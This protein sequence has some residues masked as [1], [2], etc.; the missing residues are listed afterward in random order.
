MTSDRNHIVSL[1]EQ[2]PLSRATATP[3]NT[4]WELAT[5]MP[6]QLPTQESQLKISWKFKFE[7]VSKQAF[8]FTR[9]KN[10][11]LSVPNSTSFPGGRSALLTAAAVLGEVRVHTPQRAP[12]P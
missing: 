1:R 10:N 8:N 4:R 11:L 5:L 9:R 12:A 2:T 7:L 3:A 6:R